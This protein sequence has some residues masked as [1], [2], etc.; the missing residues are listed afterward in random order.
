M[1]LIFL[2]LKIL[3]PF[4]RNAEKWPKIL[5]KSCTGNTARFLKYVLNM[6]FFN[7]MHE[8]VHSLSGNPTKWSNILKQF[9]SGF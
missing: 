1:S 9:L 4:M 5:Q 8:R 7:I 3:N 2:L 6:P